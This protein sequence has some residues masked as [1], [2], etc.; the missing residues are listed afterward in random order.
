MHNN[1]RLL[2]TKEEYYLKKYQRKK[3]IL[4][5]L[6]LLTFIIIFIL[7]M[8]SVSTHVDISSIQTLVTSDQ[9]EKPLTDD[10]QYE[11]ITLN[12]S[13]VITLISDPKAKRAG[14]SMATPLGSSDVNVKYPA[15]NKLLQKKIITEK[16]IK[17]IHD[18][19]G[20]YKFETNDVSSLYYFDIDSKGFESALEEIGNIL[21]TVPTL[22]D[23]TGNAII[24]DLKKLYEE[25]DDKTNM[26]LLLDYLLSIQSHHYDHT[27]AN[28]L[29]GN[30]HNVKLLKENFKE[31]F[32]EFYSPKNIKIALISPYS[33][34]EQKEL[35]QKYFG[36]L[37]N[38]NNI[39]QEINTNINIDKI[40]FHQFIWSKPKRTNDNKS[41]SIIL[42]SHDYKL[43]GL[44]P[45]YYFK[46]M[47]EGERPGT[48]PYNLKQRNLVKDIS[49]SIKK[50]I[51]YGNLLIFDMKLTNDG[52]EFLDNLCVILL[53]YFTAISNS[54][55]IKEIY[56]DL[57]EIYHKK[58]QFM[59]ID[60]YSN[61]LNEISFNMLSFTNQ[62][63]NDN[64]LRN[65]LY[66]NYDLEPYDSQKINSYY[67]YLSMQYSTMILQYENIF[68]KYHHILPF[69][70]E[71]DQFELRK[72]YDFNE[73]F[74]ITYKILNLLYEGLQQ[75]MVISYHYDKSGYLV[76]KKN[77]F[78][79]SL[80]VLA[81]KSEEGEIENII[82]KD[83]L[84]VYMKR[85]T[86][87][88]VPRIHSYFRLVFPDIRTEDEEQY[89]M[90]M[91]YANHIFKDFDMNFEEA[92][93][94]GND[95]KANID[96]NGINIKV[97]AYKD[98]YI[99]IM[100]T[101]FDLIF[102]LQNLVDYSALDYETK[103][104]RSIEEK[105]LNY[106]GSVLKPNVCT[107]NSNT[108]KYLTSSSI[109]E[110]TKYNAKNMYIES[111]L[112][113]DIDNEIKNQITE[114]FNQIN[115]ENNNE[116]IKKY[117]NKNNIN[118][119]LDY[120]SFNQNIQKGID[121]VYNLKE[122]FG[123]EDDNYYISFYQIGERTNELDILSTLLVNLYNDYIGKFKMDKVYKDNI[124]YLRTI[125]HSSTETPLS[126]SKDFETSL[127]IFIGKV[128]ILS[129][130]EFSSV[131]EYAKR[132]YTKNDLRLRHKAIKY[133]YEIYE[134]TFNFNRYKEIKS[135]LDSINLKSFYQQYKSFVLSTLQDSIKKVDFMIYNSNYDKPIESKLSEKYTIK[136]YSSLKY[137]Q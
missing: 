101:I 65:I 122:N 54:Q 27:F 78:L 28:G 97:A 15:L 37:K 99:N 18:N 46:Y 135:L 126:L 123:D 48:L 5:I 120:L 117:P 76:K 10:R 51:K 59:T 85:D 14:F 80:N 79:T 29:A 60:K 87:F 44:S 66:M 11:I 108:K 112:Y 98:V 7:I 35:C 83:T 23:D 89:K 95:I 92:R 31:L 91:F 68:D 106:L 39:S 16:L 73:A 43:K 64:S 20:K 100:K 25:E 116:I 118:Q 42:Y 38:R 22:Y 90:N 93:V 1:Q 74:G 57:R 41:F 107:N 94:S 71:N 121:Y 21:S 53:N 137:I 6:L 128:K 9:I 62:D 56:N 19:I 136:E 96:E 133:W 47:L 3:N 12:N 58:F 124:I 45:L 82:N 77:P 34:K 33:I 111:L 109:L 129:D 13:L 8:S 115:V 17:I 61:Y 105:A 24:S 26:S 110:Y 52:F 70:S 127:Q 81:E 30:F 119:L 75:R 114:L 113:G 125:I 103:Q 69:F 104:Y 40:A 67:Q 36:G 102:N 55:N 4:L 72:D 84:K 134:R 86:T 88:K 49:I 132:E 63:S 50:S 130:S 131:F 32:N 2:P